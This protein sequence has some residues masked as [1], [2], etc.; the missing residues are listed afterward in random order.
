MRQRYSQV[1]RPA[2]RRFTRV[3][4]AGV[5]RYRPRFR[6]AAVNRGFAVRGRVYPLRGRRVTRRRLYGRR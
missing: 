5:T 6:R 3:V 4:R 1:R 2:Y